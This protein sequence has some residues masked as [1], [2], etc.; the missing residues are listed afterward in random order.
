MLHIVNK[1]PSERATLASALEHSKALQTIYAMRQEL[2]L[3]WERSTDS[4]E[5]LL[6]RLQDWCRRAEGSGIEALA[7]FSLQLKRYA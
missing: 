4:T 7:R 3:L 6:H 2:N 1:S 5:Q